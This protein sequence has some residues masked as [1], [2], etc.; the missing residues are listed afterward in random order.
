[1]F[2]QLKL[3]G[4]MEGVSYLLLI[5]IAMPLKYLADE[6]LMVQLVGAAHGWLFVWFCG[7]L[8]IAMTRHDMSFKDANWGLLASLLPFGTFVF[9]AKILP[10]YLKRKLGSE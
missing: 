2:R 1:M 7:A 9:E 10:E 6:P 3:V 8:F 4:R 5:A